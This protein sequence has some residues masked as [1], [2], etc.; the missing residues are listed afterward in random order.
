MSPAQAAAIKS[1]RK[2]FMSGKAASVHCDVNSQ[3]QQS[4][5]R[6]DQM[7]G[8]GP[9]R[10]DFLNM[11]REIQTFGE[12]CSVHLLQPNAQISRELS[13]IQATVCF[14]LFSI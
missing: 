1:E 10:N 5:Q 9:S 4:R 13:C 7:D 6:K 2:R 3:Q 8:T 14:N 12:S 11:Q